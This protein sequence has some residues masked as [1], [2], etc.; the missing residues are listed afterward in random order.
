MAKDAKEQ[1]A[2]LA[3]ATNIHITKLLSKFS[4][5]F[6]GEEKARKE[7]RAV[8]KGAAPERASF[9]KTEYTVQTGIKRG[10]TVVGPGVFWDN[11]FKQLKPAADDDGD[12]PKKLPPWWKKLIGPALLILG[13]LAAF[14]TGIMTDGPLKGFLSLLAKGGIM[15]G[16]KLL[17][18]VLT[19]AVGTVLRGLS[20]VFG[21]E[22]V[23][24]VLKSLKS[25]MGVVF[26]PISKF[27]MSTL[28]RFFTRLIAPAANW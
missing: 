10:S 23:A 17:S 19:R 1:A 9:R 26:K 14:I 6:S 4:E 8:A 24:E 22:K 16:L 3:N 15:G 11:I 21:E 13:G 18:N 20:L 27:F 28:P 2:E 7:E 25:K 12:V 5:F